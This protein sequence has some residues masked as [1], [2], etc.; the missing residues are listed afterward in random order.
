ML[1]IP[2]QNSFQLRDPSYQWNEW[3]MRSQ[4]LQLSDLRKKKTSSAQTDLR[5]SQKEAETQ[6]SLP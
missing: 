4:A 2:W 5:S 1:S 6:V 3:E